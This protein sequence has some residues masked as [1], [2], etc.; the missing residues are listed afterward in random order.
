MCNPPIYFRLDDRI[1][2]RNKN[3]FQKRRTDTSFKF[4]SPGNVDASKYFKLVVSN[5]PSQFKAQQIN[6][7]AR[8]GFAK[9]CRIV[10]LS[11]N[12]SVLHSIRNN[13]AKRPS[14]SCSAFA[15]AMVK[16]LKWPFLFT[17]PAVPYKR[18]ICHL[19]ST[20][21]FEK[22]I[23]EGCESDI[24]S[25]RREWFMCFWS[26]LLFKSSKHVGRRE[27]TIHA[28]LLSLV[29]IDGLL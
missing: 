11:Q 22:R 8:M 3:G 10:D 13:S 4:S 21:Y 18:I 14:L 27:C 6:D 7:G 29:I 19:Y 28:R 15:V 17:L 24:R 12:T 23:F 25:A 2:V 9:R 1:H 26:S 16:F 5:E 20:H